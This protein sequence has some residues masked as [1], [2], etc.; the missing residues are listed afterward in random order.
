MRLLRLLL[1]IVA[2]FTV[3]LLWGGLYKTPVLQLG[4]LSCALVAWLMLRMAEPD[5]QKYNWRL[6]YRLPHYWLW[7]LGQMVVSNIQVLRLVLGPRSALSPVLVEVD[8][9]ASNKFALALL[10]NSI[11]LTP[12]TLT[13]D[14]DDNK[15][16]AHCLTAA[17]AQSL[18]AG[19]MSRRVARVD[20][21]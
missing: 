19:A 17:A 4:I 8:A 7:L 15:I 1:V 20:P 21:D 9:Q 14:I 11:T 16:T 10:G 13:I 5:Q 18:Q 12:G 3:W 2:L 6:A